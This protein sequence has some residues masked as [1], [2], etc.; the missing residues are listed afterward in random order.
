MFPPIGSWVGS[1]TGLTNR[2]LHVVRIGL[3]QDAIE[4][5]VHG[6]LVDAIKVLQVSE[7]DQAVVAKAI[8]LIV[9]ELCGCADCRKRHAYASCESQSKAGKLGTV[10]LSKG[11]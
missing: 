5:Q 2:G 6:W 11:N 9:S 3:S 4:I 7:R 10:G 1:V 8:G